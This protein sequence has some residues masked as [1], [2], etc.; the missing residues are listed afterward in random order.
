MSEVSRSESRVAKG[1]ILAVVVV[2]VSFLYILF[3]SIGLYPLVMSDEYNYSKY[4][5][6][7]PF[8]QG[9]LPNYLYFLIYSATSYCGDGFL[10]CSRVFNV[11]FFVCSFP[12]IYLVSRLVVARAVSFFIA[13]VCILG[14]LN[15][16]TAYYMPDSLYF[17]SFGCFVGLL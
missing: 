11:A 3:K 9:F 5:R 13:L 16:Y 17:F 2:F 15:S 7:L 8:S 10:Q 1:L 12:F 4:S 6:L 14:P